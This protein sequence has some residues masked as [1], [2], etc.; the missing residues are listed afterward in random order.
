MNIEI[1]ILGVTAFFI[2]N[3]YHDGKYIILLKS[4]KKYY[5]MGFYGFLGL[6]LYLFIKK[7]PGESHSLLKHANGIIKYMPI[8]KNTTDMLTPLFNFTNKSTPNDNYYGENRISSSSSV[9][10]GGSGTS[11]R[12]V[13][14]TKKKY[15][16]SRQNWKC[17]D[18]SQQLTAWFEVH[19]KISLENGGGNHIDNLVALCRN[20]HGAH[21]ALDNLV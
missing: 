11:K 3:S 1:I 14:E 16:A 7:H 5:Q 19:H 4:W 2:A 21:T 20:C 15:V 6:S 12:S 13:S 10:N 17:Q 18:C 9:V 8:D